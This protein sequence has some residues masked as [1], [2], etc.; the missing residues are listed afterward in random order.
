M[1]QE[2][3]N[4]GELSETP[5]DAEEVLD[6]DRIEAQN[7]AAPQEQ[8]E[9]VA[10]SDE[11][12]P[13][14]LDEEDDLS[15]ASN[16]TL[17][18]DQSSPLP[19]NA[20][21]DRNSHLGMPAATSDVLLDKVAAFER[22]DLP[23][24]DQTANWLGSLDAGGANM[25]EHGT[26][27]ES[28]ARE[29]SDWRQEVNHGGLKLRIANPK[30]AEQSEG[31]PLTGMR[32]IMKINSVLG[33]GATPRV[34]LWHS[35]MWLTFKAPNEIDLLE[36]ERRIA[37]E[38]IR[39][40]RLTNGLIFSS[41]SVYHTS[42][43][44]NFALAHVIE[45][46][47]NYGDP[48]ELKSKILTTDIPGLLLGLL[49]AI[50]PNGYQYTTSCVHDP[51]K[52]LFELQELL[53]LSKLSFVD[54]TALT[55]SQKALM[56]RRTAKFTDLEIEAYQKDHIYNRNGR[57]NVID[58]GSDVIVHTKVPTIAEYEASGINWVDSIVEKVDQAFAGRL[59]GEE[60][61]QYIMQNSVVTSVRQYGHWI[62]K[63][64]VAGSPI[65]DQDTVEQV[66]ARM[67]SDN[68]T[69]DRFFEGVG[70]FIGESTISLVALQRFICP[71]CKNEHRTPVNLKHPHLI[72][73]NVEAIFFTL[74]R[75]RIFKALRL[76]Q[77]KR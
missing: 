28:V 67:S 34:P 11:D 18:Y 61:Q 45:A 43:L 30:V 65:E 53:N 70:K 26:F 41:T 56:S 40:G 75:Q 69:F 51:K 25:L 8:D 16:V 76:S 50:Y 72:P 31:G 17:D 10:A 37:E 74:L 13:I 33:L 21:L 63:I 52:C 60:R 32:A 20:K 58:C 59:Q 2:I 64:V 12:T 1:I 42:Y 71:S 66:L 49:C 9:P 57:L 44:V 36:L 7:T 4:Q 6:I 39:L 3:D 19:K 47:Y 77:T 5:D 73:L 14:S 68:E 48:Q 38:K 55:D 35:G 15:P 22:L 24:N 29:G 27:K 46:T 23:V 62:D 54:T